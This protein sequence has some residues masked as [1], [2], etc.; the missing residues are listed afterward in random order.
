VVAPVPNDR[1]PPVPSAAAGP[2]TDVDVDVVAKFRTGDRAAFMTVYDAYAAQV[3]PLVNRF[4]FRPFER[5]EAFQEVW[6]QVHR[7]APTYDAARGE[8]LP[9]L[10][11]VAAN[12]CK[13]LL[14]ARGRRP[15]PDVLLQDHDLVADTDP[16]QTART[17]RL[18]AAITRFEAT[19]SSEEA[20]VFR[21][22]LLEE[23]GHDE[24][25]RLSGLSPRR[26]KYL[27]MKLLVRAAT[28]GELRRALAEVTSP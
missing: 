23:R 15:D 16:E 6:L 3:R 5:E 14:R 20:Q 21:W 7:A 22:S 18:Q 4:F 8:L 17:T 24:V 25:A 11:T 12:R 10:R 28:D 1:V 2:S 27:R 19:L 9:W 26:C 13:E